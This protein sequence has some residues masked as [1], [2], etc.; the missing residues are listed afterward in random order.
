MFAGVIEAGKLERAL[1]L[2]ERLHLEKSYDL[3]I[4]IADNHS[5]LAD[6]IEDAKDRKFGGPAENADAPAYTDYAAGYG[7]DD[8]EEGEYN[9]YDS[10]Q[11]ITPDSQRKRSMNELA[12]NERHVRGRKAGF[13]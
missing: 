2:V 10:S 11:R 7:D 12:D 13:T 5:A 8:E 9:D 3:A 4:T 6:L 1:D